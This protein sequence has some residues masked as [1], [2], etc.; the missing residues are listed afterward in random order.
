MYVFPGGY[1]AMNLRRHIVI[2]PLLCITLFTFAR[3]QTPRITAS[4]LHIDEAV[5]IVLTR[6]AERSILDAHLARQQAIRL[7]AG[8]LPNPSIGYTHEELSGTGSRYAEW[9]ATV[10]YPLLSLLFRG[11]RTEAADMNVRAAVAQNARA[12]AD[13]MYE[14]REQYLDTW[15]LRNVHQT[16]VDIQPRIRSLEEVVSA[17]QEEGDISS[18]ERHRL[19]TELTT[20]QWRVTTMERDL[21]TAEARLAALLSIPLDSLRQIQLHL[22]VLEKIDLDLPMLVDITIKN[23]S[24]LVSLRAQRAALEHENRWL[25]KSW[26]EDFRIGGGYKHQSDTYSGPVLTLS[27]PIPLFE[28]KQGLRAENEAVQSM[29]DANTRILERKVVAEIHNAVSAYEQI[30]GQAA[31]FYPP[32][33]LGESDLLATASEAYREGEFSLVEYLDALTAHTDGR[34][35]NHTV[36]AAVL[37][38]AFRLELAVERNLFS[39]QQ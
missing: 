32:N 7:T 25:G 1:F 3:A 21:H 16:L 22:P 17:R 2:Y 24:D 15:K 31:A 19:H 13:L 14:V 28:R 11:S 4:T 27:T 8:I 20:L 33:Q 26:L 12:I 18:Y 23:R 29:L 6:S 30:I 5:E 36:R 35:L 9:S 39:K 37:T 34:E 38:A 10:D